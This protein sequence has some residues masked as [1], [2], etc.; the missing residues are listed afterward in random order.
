MGCSRRNENNLLGLDKGLT[1]YKKWVLFV[2]GCWRWLGGL[3]VDR[4]KD[5]GKAGEL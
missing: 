1:C 2:G 5:V 4:N 3:V